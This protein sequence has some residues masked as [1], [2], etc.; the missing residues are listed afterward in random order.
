MCS[1]TIHIVKTTHMDQIKNSIKWALMLILL[2]PIFISAQELPMDPSVRIGKLDNG[3]TYY[4]KSNPKPENRI[5]FRL[6]VKA[7]SVLE[8]D[9]QQ[10]LAHFVEHMLFNGTKNFE[11]NE[12]IDF[13][14]NMGLEFGGD[15]NAY[16]SFDETVYILPIPTEDP[17]NV[18][19]ALLVLSDW[20]H[21]ATFD[22]EEIDKERGVVME[23]W[24]LRLGAYDR[25]RKQIWPVTLAG[26]RYAERLPIGKPEIIENFEHDAAKRYYRDWYRPDLMAVVAVGDF[27]IDEMEAKIKSN[28]GV[29]EKR[30]S[31]RERTEFEKPDFDGTRV[32]IA[33]DDEATGNSI[34]VNF[35]TP[36]TFERKNDKE[37]YRNSLLR[38]LYSSMINQ[39]LN[40]LTRSENPPFQFSYSGYGGSLGK[41]KF[42]YTISV[43]VR[44]GEFEGGL[45]AAVRE[46]ERVR[47]YGFT[48]GEF[49]RAKALYRNSYERRVKEAD[50]Q[51]S[52]RIV[53]R[54][55]SHFL[56]GG[57]LLNEQQQLDL[58]DEMLEGVE[59]AEINE[60]IKG[61]IRDD[62]RTIEIM[63]KSENAE[64]IPT[65]E[66]L[67]NILDE[68]KN[69]TSIEPYVEEVIATSLM[70]SM[71]AKG[72]IT[73][74]ETDEKTGITHLTLSNGA[75]VYIKPTDFKNDEIRMT[76]Y[77]F[78]G[79]SLYSDEE[80]WTVSNAS[81]IA[82]QVG[83]GEFTAVDLGK[84]M[85]G[86]TASVNTFIGAYEEGA[87]GFS[88]IKDIETF[89]QMLHMKFTT[90]RDD[91]AAFNSW[92]T[93][94]KNLYANFMSSPDLQWQ[95]QLQ[96]LMY[97]DHPR[98][99]FPTAENFDAINYDR[100]REVYLERFADAS[101]FQFVFVGNI[102]MA[103][104][105]PL[106]EQYVASLPATNSNEMFKDV[107][108]A[109][110]EGQM[111]ESIY[112]GVDDKSSVQIT[113]HG[114][115]DYSLENNGLMNA[116]A[117]ILS[118]KMIETLREDM[119]GVYG[120]GA[121]A[122][123]SQRPKSTYQFTIS[124]PCKPDNVEALTQ[125]ALAE[126]EKIKAG[127]FTEE[128]LE[129][130]ITARIQNFDESI[131]QNRYWESMIAAYLKSDTDFEKILEGNERA[132]AI[133]KDKVVATAN[134]YLTGENMVKA[135]KLPEKMKEGDLTQEIKK[136]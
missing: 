54:Y 59:L 109:I 79:S 83:V 134:K 107:G 131:K 29:I 135:V 1:L 86:K 64:S 73:A 119:G 8:D 66:T 22:N 95:I 57:S 45:R 31:P 53:N 23:E 101:D 74:E 97:G 129:K 34:N 88:S 82:S 32:A 136:N 94:T 46:N 124:F 55:V 84:F 72:A 76:A 20:A 104:F 81:Q 71:P 77:S 5:E 85:T 24:R 56:N 92:L 30:T 113:L 96:E 110:K 122:S 116:I 127:D 50:K 38:G 108:I 40:E 112:V 36:G 35:I 10:G 6:A 49:T 132:E 21:Q 9:D 102:D 44:E 28:F 106:L 80:Y 19:D 4:L 120:A 13:L 11:K 125:A 90:V 33:S 62:N 41:G 87:S 99:G 67:I 133:T 25:M 130:V 43:N 70:S 117:S 118:N 93:R 68:A 7:G 75:N 16:T 128:D 52:W 60:L 61:W 3:F 89:M 39:R 65:D 18:D 48:E 2:T 42:E 26:S 47:R 17:K 91:K 12:L 103:S 98:V 15:L 105:K 100:A 123:L 114:E 37:S 63:A 78:G 51:E 58:L 14:Q 111:D 69:D 121:R 126:L 115:Y 27:D